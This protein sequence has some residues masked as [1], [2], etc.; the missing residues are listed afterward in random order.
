MRFRVSVYH[1]TVASSAE[2]QQVLDH[3]ALLLG[4]L[5]VTHGEK[6][7]KR[8]AILKPKPEQNPLFWGRQPRNWTTFLLFNS[9][10]SRGVTAET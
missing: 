9:D 10:S 5:D 8:N 7:K 3:N 6:G 2:R 1:F 4:I